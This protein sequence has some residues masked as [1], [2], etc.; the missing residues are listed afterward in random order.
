MT[1]EDLQNIDV[2]IFYSLIIVENEIGYTIKSFHHK[3]FIIYNNL[4]PK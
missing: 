2:K 4:S 3:L 1:R